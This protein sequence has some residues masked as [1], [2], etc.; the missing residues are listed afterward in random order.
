[1]GSACRDNRLR[2][3]DREIADVFRC[4]L[5]YPPLT[6]AQED[7]HA[8]WLT[9]IMR[10]VRLTADERKE[11]LD[12]LRTDDEAF[13]QDAWEAPPDITNLAIILMIRQNQGRAGFKELYDR[14][15]K[16]SW[17]GEPTPPQDVP[18][19]MS[20]PPPA[21]A[22]GYDGA[23]A[24][25]ATYASAF[26]AVPAQARIVPPEQD[27]GRAAPLAVPVLREDF[28]NTLV[29]V[30]PTVIPLHDVGDRWALMCVCVCSVYC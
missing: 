16:P 18:P 17:F 1:M 12:G 4:V 11:Y 10:T 27:D 24:G 15:P 2:S 20:L 14:T 3:F 26:T 7:E 9:T 8:R 22:G 23:A 6:A 19:P 25:A 21:A 29:A 30:I 28:D 13:I 5:Q